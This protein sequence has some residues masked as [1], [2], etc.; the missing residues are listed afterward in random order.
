MIDRQTSKFITPHFASAVKY[1]IEWAIQSFPVPIHLAA[2]TIQ[3]NGGTRLLLG[4]N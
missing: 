2:S 1:G 3:Y 4:H